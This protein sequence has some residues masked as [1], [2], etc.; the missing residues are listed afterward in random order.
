M[1]DLKDKTVV[2][3]KEEEEE[4]MVAEEVVEEAAVTSKVAKAT[5]LKDS[6]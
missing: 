6:K 2:A 1:T 4:A 5:D 3:I